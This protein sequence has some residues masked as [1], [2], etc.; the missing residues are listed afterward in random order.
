MVKTKKPE[1]KSTVATKPAAGKSKK[2][3]AA[4]V[5]TVA[6][7][8]T[9]PDLVV[10]TQSPNSTLQVIADLLDR[11]PFQACVELTRRLLTS[12]STLPTGVVRQRAVLKTIILFMAVYGSTPYDD[13]TV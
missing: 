13:G 2:K 1:P 12:I 3:A 5:K 11:L 7:K 8:S 9:T 4:N 6:A 10:P